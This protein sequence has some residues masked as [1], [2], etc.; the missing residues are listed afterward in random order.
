MRRILIV[1]E[2]SAGAKLGFQELRQTGLPTRAEARI[3]SIANVNLFSSR[4]DSFSIQMD[5]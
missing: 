2:A 1:Y 3:L 5:T 4:K